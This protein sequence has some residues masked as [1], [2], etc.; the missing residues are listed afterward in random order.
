MICYLHIGT[1]KTGTTSIQNWLYTNKVIL[2]NNE[3]FLSNF[4]SI[5]NNRSLANFFQTDLDD[6]SIINQIHDNN[7]KKKFF[8]NFLNK[9]KEEVNNYKKFGKKFIITSEHF[10]SR[11]RTKEEIKNLYN[12]L[13]KIFDQIIIIC[14]FRNQSELAL[15]YYS[16]L[17]KTSTIL[18]FEDF[19]DSNLKNNFYYYDHLSIANNWSEF[20]GIENCIF[21]IY[22]KSVFIDSDIR[23]DFIKIISN[24]LDLN[25]FNWV[26]KDNNRSLFKAQGIIFKL[27]NKTYPYW[28]QNKKGINPINIRLKNEILK[29]E[30]F[31]IGSWKINSHQINKKFQDIND[32]FFAKYI[33]N[34]SSFPKKTNQNNI[35]ILTFE[36]LEK[37]ISCIIEF[38]LITISKKELLNEKEINNIR[39]IALKINKNLLTDS[40]SL[41]KIASKL[42][43]NGKFIKNKIIEFEKLLKI[44]KV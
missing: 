20:F 15:S 1:E 19:L 39:D 16:T 26:E 21:R 6:F 23:K 38:N 2:E 33:K 28:D 44:K 30:E 5:N 32:K 35:D 25:Q 42:R 7:D 8:E 43:P 14:Y 40:I 11:L 41:L 37:L 10:S 31:Q 4:L 12:F 13:S 17:L 24:D 3:I 29:I 34:V 22:D 36:I 9:F 18:D 27:I